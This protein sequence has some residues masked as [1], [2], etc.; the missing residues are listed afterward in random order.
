M[1][2]RRSSALVLLLAAAVIAAGCSD[3]ETDTG[4]KA[5]PTN[6]VRSTSEVLAPPEPD[7][8]P[9][10]RRHARE[11]GFQRCDP[12]IRV[13]AATTTCPFAQNAFYG[14]WKSDGD[15]ELRVYSP[16]AKRFFE[17]ACDAAGGLVTCTTGDGGVVKFAQAAV[18][19]YTE[20]DA[21]TFAVHA[22]LG[23]KETAD[24][25]AASSNDAGLRSHRD[26]EQICYP[27]FTVPAVT[28]PAVTIPAVTIPAFDFGGHHYPAK[29][30]PA[31]HYPAQHYPAQH[32]D[33]T[34]VDA[35]RAFAPTRTTVLDDSAYAAIDDD[36]SPGLTQHYWSGTG[37]AI[38]YPDTTAP[39]FGE[40]NDAGFP[41]NQYVRPYMRSDGTYVD[42]YWRNSPSDGLPTCQIVDC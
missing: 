41:K 2:E 25:G 3:Q 1:R 4:T 10:R 40:Y 14:Y 37:T 17:T 38:D 34:C 31:Q 5:T 24:G 13:K 26:V 7:S 11:P 29:H 32:Y 22:D 18:D 23:P 8:S 28:I 39:G 9:S 36:Y 33:A 30:Y 15:S 35:P 16:A 27:G 12:N 6:T 42:G 21:R 20:T 19:R